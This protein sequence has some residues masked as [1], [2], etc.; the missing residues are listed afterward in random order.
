MRSPLLPLAVL[1]LLAGCGTSPPG[2]RQPDGQGTGTATT[3]TA[4]ATTS[5]TPGKPGC[6]PQSLVA[7][8][9]QQPEPHCLR[10][11]DILTITTETSP[12]QPW[13]LPASSDESILRCVAHPLADGATTA[14]CT[15]LRHGTA[16][17][18]TTTAAFAG[19]PHGPPQSQWQLRVEVT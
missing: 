13:T 18:T 16:E 10:V 1:L 8:V 11:G 5:S 15:A 17:V 6:S 14:T 19:D 12:H 7:T 4:S 3:G 9:R 2:G